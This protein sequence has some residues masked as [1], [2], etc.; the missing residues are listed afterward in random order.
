VARYIPKL[1]EKL[2][3]NP[4]DALFWLMINGDKITRLGT[5]N[6]SDKRKLSQDINE[7]RSSKI[8]ARK[9]NHYSKEQNDI[10]AVNRRSEQWAVC[11]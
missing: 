7:I 3:D 8:L 10:W 11:K 6:G 5:R 9:I 2:W 4:K 1:S